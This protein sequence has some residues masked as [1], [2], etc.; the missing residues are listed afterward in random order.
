MDGYPSVLNQLLV[1]KDPHSRHPFGSRPFLY[2]IKRL[3]LRRH[4][5]RVCLEKSDDF[6]DVDTGGSRVDV[7]GQGNRRAVLEPG[8]LFYKTVLNVE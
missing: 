5:H 4:C 8:S 7:G 3:L 1:G 2:S 6:P